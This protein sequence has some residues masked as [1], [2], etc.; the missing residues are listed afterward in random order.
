MD[1]KYK[2]RI[3]KSSEI[4]VSRESR[5]VFSSPLA[6]FFLKTRFI[7]Y[8]MRPIELLPAIYEWAVKGRPL[9]ILYSLMF[10]RNLK[11]SHP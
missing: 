4:M 5:A 8:K 3:L 2:L 10:L 9:D 11:S 1:C 6:K 7:L